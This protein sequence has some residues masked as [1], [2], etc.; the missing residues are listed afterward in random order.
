MV[1]PRARLC[2]GATVT[3]PILCSPRP[4]ARATNSYVPGMSATVAGSGVA[5]DVSATGTARP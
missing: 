4:G 1:P 5:A 2:P 3:G